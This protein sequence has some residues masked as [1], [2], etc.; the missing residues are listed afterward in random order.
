MSGWRRAVF[1]LLVAGSLLG[2]SG[3]QAVHATGWFGDEQCAGERLKSG[4]VGP[5]G[6]ECARECIRRGVKVVFL[7]EGCKSLYRVENPEVTRGIECD[8]VEIRG[9]VDPSRRSVRVEHIRVRQPC[10]AKCEK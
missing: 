7:D 10:V 6:R 1:L 2:A 5:S 3:G 8:S 4:Q 9:T